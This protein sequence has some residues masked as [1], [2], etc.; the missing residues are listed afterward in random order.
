[1]LSENVLNKVIFG[2]G[3]EK[4]LCETKKLC[5]CVRFEFPPTVSIC[6]GEIH[7]WLSF[8]PFFYLFRFCLCS[9]GKGKQGFRGTKG[10]F[11]IAD[12]SEKLMFRAT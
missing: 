3:G 4:N 7:E 1:M 9:D 6:Y 2:G 5:W 10:D 8:G 12:F 11:K